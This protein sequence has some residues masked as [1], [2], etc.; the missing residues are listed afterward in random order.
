MVR[1]RNFSLV[2]SLPSSFHV[3]VFI[4]LDL[5]GITSYP[6][7]VDCQTCIEFHPP[8][9]ISSIRSCTFELVVTGV[10]SDR[11]TQ[12]RCSGYQLISQ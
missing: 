9:N 12:P 10:V 11:F 5:N 3:Q 8:P 2:S 7:C 4:I 1:L 6:G